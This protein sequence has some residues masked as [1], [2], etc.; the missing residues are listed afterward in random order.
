MSYFKNLNSESQNENE[1]KEETDNNK[2]EIGKNENENEEIENEEKEENEKLLQSNFKNTSTIN[3]TDKEDDNIIYEE[4]FNY[5]LPNKKQ[6][7]TIKECKNAMR[8][9]G[10]LITEKELV[11]YLE[12]NEKNG[13]EK[14]NLNEFISLCKMKKNDDYYDE[15]EE[16]FKFYDI[17]ETGFVN[18]KELKHA[19]LIFKPKMNEEEIDQILN[20]YN[21]DED[22]FIN[23]KE[24]L[25]S[26]K[27]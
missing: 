22:G 19:M 9:L 4:F 14:I 25:N 16:A 6:T 13:K 18:S 8:C 23:Y 10:I 20:E 15:L 21:I 2:N 27:K 1:E 7:L 24:Y 5:F 26:T 11:E 17:N 3:D 12:I